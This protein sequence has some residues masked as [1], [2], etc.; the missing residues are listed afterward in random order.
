MP[1]KGWAVE[2]DGVVISGSDDPGDGCLV[3]PPEGLGNPPIRTE[4]VTFPQRDGVR[5]FAD[6]YEP[7]IITLQATVCPGNDSCG[8]NCPGAREHVR[9]ILKAWGR[10]CDDVELIV[11]TD[12]SDSLECSSESPGESP[13][14]GALRTWELGGVPGTNVTVGN[15]GLSLVNPDGG[16]IVYNP[17]GDGI[18]FTSDADGSYTIARGAVDIPDVQVAY[19]GEFMI[20]TAPAAELTFGVIRQSSGDIPSVRIMVTPA[21]EV[22]LRQAEAAG[23]AILGTLGTIQMGVRYQLTLVMNSGAGTITGRLYTE[24]GNQLGEVSAGPGTNLGDS[25]LSGFEIGIISQN[26]ATTVNWYEVAMESGRTTEIPP[27]G[28][29][30]VQ[31]RSLV[32][33]YGILGRPRLATVE[34]LRGRSGCARITLRFDARDHRMFILDCEGGTGEICVTAEPNV[35][36]MGRTYPRCYTGDGMCFD[37]MTGRESGDALAPVMGVECASS[38]LCFYGQL[39]NP[40]LRNVTT[41]QT[42]GISG[43]IPSGTDP[44]CIDTDTGIATQAGVSRT[45]LITGNPRMTLVPGENILR[46]TSTEATDNGRVDICYRPFAVS[47]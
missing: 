37:C 32:G 39:T 1:R 18:V 47:A 44:I 27:A 40:I 34:W 25:T 16:T 38:V 9:N 12:C 7:R 30:Q 17:D 22:Q 10:R 23:G 33:P 45:H 6:W 11:W 28:Q 4:D 13:G 14:D 3:A 8:G 2:L 31:D 5:H 20:P 46:L 43:I 42:V 15:S 19:L 29:I 41:G 36:T 26:P 35:E 21:Q 24:N